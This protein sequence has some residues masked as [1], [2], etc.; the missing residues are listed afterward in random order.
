MKILLICP[1]SEI[2]FTQENQYPLGLLY[3]ASALEKDKHQIVVKDYYK[4][5]WEKVKKKIIR[6]IKN[7]SPEVIG[8]NCMT[9]NRTSCFKLAELIKKISPQTKIIMGGVHASSLYEQILL[10]FPVDAIILGEGEISTPKLIKA[11][12]KKT[13]IKRIKGIA[14]K[15]KNKVKVNKLEEHIKN[16]DEIAFPKHEL[17]KSVMKKTKTALMITSRGCPYNCIFCSTAEYWGRRWR[18]RSAKNVVDE[19]EFILTKFPYVEN[20]VFYD[21]TFILD[22]KRVIDICEDI[23]KRGLKFNWTCSGRIDRV[24]EVMLRKMKKAGCKEIIYGVESGSEKILKVIDKKITKEQIKKTI[25]ITN[26]VKLKY[27]T[28]LM[29]GNPGETWGTIRETVSFLKELKNLEVNAV[30]RLEIYPNTKVYQLA[31]QQKIIDDSF[32]LTSKIVPHYTYE[33]S[34][35]ELTNMAYYIVAKNQLNKGIWNF[36]KFAI[37]FFRQKPKKAIRYILIKIINLVKF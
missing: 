11:F 27:H 5:S 24:S 14:F 10:N 13:P 15:E 29:V 20:I 31:K 17:C 2:P 34:E 33:H 21:D 16:L 6:D 19:I 37:R 7:F 12:E 4:N 35:D 8:L 3:L 18:A 28:Y 22:N 26:K 32:W 25:Q 9:R 36:L 30:G 23:I 1:P